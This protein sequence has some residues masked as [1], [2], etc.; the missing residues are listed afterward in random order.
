MCVCAHTCD[1]NVR[2]VPDRSRNATYVSSILRVVM[3]ASP[4]PLHAHALRQTTFS[5]RGLFYFSLM[6][7]DCSRLRIVSGQRPAW[8]VDRTGLGTA[9]GLH[10]SQGR[11]GRPY[12][13][14]MLTCSIILRP[15]RARSQGKSS[16]NALGVRALADRVHFSSHRWILVVISSV[17]SC[18]PSEDLLQP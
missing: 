5:A 3:R 9:R 12:T 4:Q 10:K 14:R 18:P 8:P 11:A 17:G 15:Y 1:E 2:A 16:T 7:V 6:R 13:T